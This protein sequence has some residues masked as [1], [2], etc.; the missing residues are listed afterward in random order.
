MFTQDLAYAL[1]LSQQPGARQNG[2][3]WGNLEGRK[4]SINLAGSLQPAYLQN[5][6]AS[7]TNSS[8]DQR[9]MSVKAGGITSGVMHL[10]HTL[11]CSFT[12]CAQKQLSTIPCLR[13]AH[14]AGYA[15]IYQS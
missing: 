4:P 3:G 8:I 2:Y 6:I 1:S 5:Q 11:L 15:V 7:P 10:C 9:A 12:Q 14:I 13:Q